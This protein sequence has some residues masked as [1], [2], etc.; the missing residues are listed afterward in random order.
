MEW[1]ALYPHL[2]WL[3]G[4]VAAALIAR[5]W[6]V[7]KATAARLKAEG[8][9]V[10]AKTPVEVESLAVSSLEVVA[11]R[12]SAEIERKTNENHALLGRAERAEAALEVERE[13]RRRDREEHR[14]EV[15]ELENRLAALQRD[16]AIYKRKLSDEDEDQS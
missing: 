6:R 1:A 11:K 13:G 16:L 14:R 3:L 15:Q 4:V 12:Q 9:A 7:E 8:I 2:L 10:G 5:Q